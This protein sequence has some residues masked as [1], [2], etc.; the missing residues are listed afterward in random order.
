MKNR[1]RFIVHS[2]TA[3]ELFQ[4]RLFN[5]NWKKYFYW[6]NDFLQ[7]KKTIIFYWTFA[8]SIERTILLNEQ[9][10]STINLFK[11]SF[12]QKTNKVLKTTKYKFSFN[13]GKKIGSLMNDN[14]TNW[15]R[16]ESDH[17][18]SS[19]PWLPWR[20]CPSLLLLSLGTLENAPISTPPIPGYP[21]ECAHLYSS[22]PWLPWRMSPSLLF[23]SLATLENVPLST[24]PIPGYP[25]E[26]A[27]LYSS[28]PWLH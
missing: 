20:M 9:S 15:K 1:L 18:Y 11:W 8:W 25:G 17:L 7:T 19:Y 16:G 24:T 23:L 14:R 22:Y 26:C 27:H 2:Q 28:Y 12:R 3:N 21:G 6:T 10:Y 5:R 4:N 13:D